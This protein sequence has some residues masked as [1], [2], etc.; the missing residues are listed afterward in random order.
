MNKKAKTVPPLIRD[1]ST[2]VET[3]GGNF[4]DV[5]RPQDSTI[6]LTDIAWALSQTCRFGGHCSRY[7]SV[8]EH[9]VF[10]SKRLERRGYS[11]LIQLAGLHH[12]DAEA[13]LGD[14]PTPIKPLLGHSYA[15]ITNLM[16]HAIVRALG[17]PF[18]HQTSFDGLPTSLKAFSGPELKDADVWALLVE[19]RYL[20]PSEGKGWAIV[21]EWKLVEQPSRIITPD[22]WLGGLTSQQAYATFLE[23]HV[24]LTERINA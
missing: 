10:V 15:Y 7:Y 4:V 22:Y 3:H 12:D 13:Y 6:T 23:R 5:A 1:S 16:D 14:I 9:S 18:E 19:A 17:L 24:E 8:A 11:P 20:L 2:Q 21:R